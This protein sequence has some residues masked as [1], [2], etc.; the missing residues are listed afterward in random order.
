MDWM[1]KMN[2]N[3]RCQQG[4]NS[5]RCREKQVIYEEEEQNRRDKRALNY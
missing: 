4:V 1:K 3:K 5:G 2:V